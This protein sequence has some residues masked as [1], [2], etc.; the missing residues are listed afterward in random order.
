MGR[1]D[2]NKRR[3]KL[4][5]NEMKCCYNGVTL[6]ECLHSWAPSLC[7]IYTHAN[8]LNIE[9][10]LFTANLWLFI[11]THYC[12]NLFV[13]IFRFLDSYNL[14]NY[15]AFK[16][17]ILKKNLKTGKFM[18]FHRPWLNKKVLERRCILELEFGTR[19]LQNLIIF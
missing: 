3:H 4:L 10:V 12:S 17:R 18:I 7:L 2:K 15:D 19:L 13:I 16:L 9:D 1:Y 5:V 11:L 6:I 8:S 14:G